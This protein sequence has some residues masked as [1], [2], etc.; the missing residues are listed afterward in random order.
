MC[1]GEVIGDKDKKCFITLGDRNIRKQIPPTKKYV[2]MIER[3]NVCGRVNVISPCNGLESKQLGKVEEINKININPTVNHQNT[4]GFRPNTMGEVGK[5]DKINRYPTV[6][7]QKP[8]VFKNNKFLKGKAS[9][10]S[11][12]IRL[13]IRI[14]K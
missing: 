5:F 2:S 14:L 9:C 10:P 6:N 12:K 7:T 1:G 4:N 8:K 11:V 3:L 13:L